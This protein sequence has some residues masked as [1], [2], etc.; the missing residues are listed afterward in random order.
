M[1]TV[2]TN[3]IQTVFLLVL[4]NNCLGQISCSKDRIVDNWIYINSLWYRE[5]LDIDSLVRVSE[6]SRYSLGTWT[7]KID[8]TYTTTIDTIAKRR[9]RGHF[10]TI[11]DKCEIRLGRKKKTP[12]GLIFHILFLDEKYL[13][14]KCTKPKGDLVYLYK[15][16]PIRSTPK[17]VI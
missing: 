15:R 3:F 10:E 2:I 13:I 5:S 11:D 16:G 12:E 7:F 6:K 1:K 4:V 9:S 8:G 14:L 17:K